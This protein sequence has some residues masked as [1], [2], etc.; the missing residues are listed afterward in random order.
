LH[1]YYR[2]L[3][4]AFGFG[5]FFVGSLLLGFVLAPIVWLTIW[6]PEKRRSTVQGVLK[7]GYPF[8]L[9]WMRLMRL[10]DYEP[11]RLPKDVDPTKGYV[12]IANHPTI[13]DI[14]FM[15]GS[16]D[17]LT[18]IAK[19]SWYRFPFFHFLLKLTHYVPGTGIDG[20]DDALRTPALDRLVAQLE[21]GRPLAMFPEGTR[22][23]PGRLGRFRRGAFEAAIRANVPL[24]PLVIRCDP[25]LLYKGMRMREYPLEAG[26]FTFDW[27]PVFHPAD[28]PDVDSLELQRRYTERYRVEL[29]G[30]DSAETTPTSTTS[31]PLTPAP[32]DREPAVRRHSV[33]FD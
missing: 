5:M 16:F 27:L 21:R 18:T 28:E 11:P 29:F 20:D 19:A 7:R 31:T 32:D 3:L 10:I 2:T 4:V 13:I 17:R 23:P 12:V 6:S 9:W 26:R 8:F 30:P 15:L 25:P 33:H 1:R 24:V 14:L 22:S